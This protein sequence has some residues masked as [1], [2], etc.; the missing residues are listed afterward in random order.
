MTTAN[1][2]PTHMVYHVEERAGNE[3]G[4]WTKLG[5]LWPHKDG[6]GWN[7]QLD[8]VPTNFDGKLT[9]RVNRPKEANQTA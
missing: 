5:A 4:R 2:Q 8:Y 6:E 7:M 3:S 9:V 1:N